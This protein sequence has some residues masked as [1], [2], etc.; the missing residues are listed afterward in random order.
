M[1]MMK[2]II[3]NGVPFERNP[4]IGMPW[5]KDKFEVCYKNDYVRM[6]KDVSEGK[7]DYRSLF[8]EVI[9]EDLFFLTYF[10]VKP[11]IRGEQN[12]FNHPFCVKACREVEDG[13]KDYTLDIWAR[14]HFKSSIITIGET[15]QDTLRNP[16]ETTALLSYTKKSAERFLSSIMGI[17]ENESFLYECFSDVLFKK[18]AYE[19]SLWSVEKGINVNRGSNNPT[20]TISA[21]GMQ[22]GMPTGVHA[23]R[24]KYDDITTED[25][26]KSPAQMEDCKVK[27]D[28]SQNLGTEGGTSRVIG[29]PYHHA[30]PLAYIKAMKDIH[31]EDKYHLRLKPATDNGLANGNPVLMSRKRIEDLMSY[32]TF[33]C[34]QLLN[35]TPDGGTKLSSEFLREIEPELIPK[36][37]YNCMVIDPAGDE[38][39]TSDEWGAWVVGVEPRADQIGASNIY[40]TNG[41]LDTLKEV[42]APD[43]LARLY[44]S[45]GL[46]M[47]TGYERNLNTTPGWLVHFTNLLRVKGKHLSEDNGNLIK[48]KHGG[49]NKHLRIETALALPLMNGKI[50]ISK[51]IPFIY[52]QRLMSEMDKFPYWH[53][54]GLDALAYLYDILQDYRFPNNADTLKPLPKVS[55]AYA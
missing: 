33:N 20:P 7:V 41:Y 23:N 31:G 34:Q 38:T 54:N 27:F 3:I 5:E 51:A 39:E 19:S 13:P 10:V 42:M 14:E 1:D 52:R 15:I 45:T 4:L 17:L 44:C 29:T 9:L 40:I 36:N 35:P 48:L 46:I 6:A 8:R 16:E 43:V 50:H 30:D 37:L 21:W 25:M 49:R 22:E 11:F 24:R 18:P 12:K 53:D 2:N 28:S 55:Y 26:A 32:S 47:K